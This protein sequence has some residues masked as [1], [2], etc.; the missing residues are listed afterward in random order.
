MVPKVVGS[1]PIFHPSK[2]S[3]KVSVT[4]PFVFLAVSYAYLQGTAVVRL[5]KAIGRL[6]K[7]AI[8]LSAQHYLLP[9]CVTLILLGVDGCYRDKNT[10]FVDI[11]KLVVVYRLEDV[12]TICD[13]NVCV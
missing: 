4:T 1:N 10:C 8:L 5:Y 13:V 7:D 11:A 3:N 2:R 12:H 6:G 9:S